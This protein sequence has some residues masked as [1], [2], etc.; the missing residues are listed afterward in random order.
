VPLIPETEQTDIG[1]IQ[2]NNRNQNPGLLRTRIG[3]TEA[4]INDSKSNTPQIST[5]LL[6]SGNTFATQFQI[7]LAESASLQTVQTKHESQPVTEY[8][9]RPI[10]QYESQ[11]IF[12]HEPHPIPRFVAS[13]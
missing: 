2:L 9:H 10:I 4:R 8:K 1:Q 5:F 6:F 12:Q 11:P 7:P 3:S 13:V